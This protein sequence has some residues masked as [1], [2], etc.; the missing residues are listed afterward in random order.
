MSYQ[1]VGI[2]DLPE[3]MRPREKLAK[4]GENRLDDHELIAIIWAWAQQVQCPGHSP[5]VDD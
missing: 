5:A 3:D 1:A 4:L 2:K